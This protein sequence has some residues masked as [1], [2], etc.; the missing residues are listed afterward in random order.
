[1]SNMQPTVCDNLQVPIELFM[2]FRFPLYKWFIVGYH[3]V[4]SA[5]IDL[6][7]KYEEVHVLKRL[8]FLIPLGLMF[9]G[10]ASQ[11]SVI[12]LEKRVDAL[13]G[14]MGKAESR[15]TALESKVADMD[16]AQSDG[17]VRAEQAA[18]KAEKAVEMMQKKG[19]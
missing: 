5:L 8:L 18:E 9:I 6:L 13:E 4:H 14:R 7:N 16:K 12:D 1:M 15:I 17:T 3:T 10:C 2:I 19:R 11:Q